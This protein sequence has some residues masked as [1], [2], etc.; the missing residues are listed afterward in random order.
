[1]YLPLL[2]IVLLLVIG[3][4]AL[5]KRRSPSPQ[6]S[7]VPAAAVMAMA[8]LLASAT[9]LRNRDYRSALTL[10]QTV[11][12]RW[13]TGIAYHILGEQLLLAGRDADAI[14]PLQEAVTR[15]DSRAG[16]SLGVALSNSGDLEGALPRL[17]A[18]V[19]TSQLPYRLVPRWLEPPRA[20]VVSARLLM[21]R[22]FSARHEWNQ[23]AEQADLA[24]RL[25]PSHAEVR[26]LLADALFREEQWQ[27][28]GVEYTAYLELR[29][30]DAAALVNL[31][32]THAA[33]GQF[34]DAVIAFRRALQIDPADA[35]AKTLL[36]I[37]LEDQRREHA[38]R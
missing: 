32:M 18:F 17:D 38:G 21:A 5:W 37:A 28:A 26:R 10:A 1:M 25:A 9:V 20:D 14:A 22:I 31:G 19:R 6:F 30:D 7:I 35:R 8:A 2:A 13:P 27:R 24:L 36:G 16:Y 12:D 34:D 33:T 3:M 29:P 4:D 11:V 15:G 23:A